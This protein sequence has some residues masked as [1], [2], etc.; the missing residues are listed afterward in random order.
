MLADLCAGSSMRGHRALLTRRDGSQPFPS[1]VPGRP[2]QRRFPAKSP[3]VGTH[4]VVLG[5]VHVGLEDSTYR[6]R[7]NVWHNMWTNCA[8][9]VLRVQ[10]RLLRPSAAEP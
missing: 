8:E 10:S 2:R 5:I 6:R 3:W 9:R 1:R 4:G 7:T